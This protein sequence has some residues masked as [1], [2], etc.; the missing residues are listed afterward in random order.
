M[1][2]YLLDWVRYLFQLPDYYR[3]NSIVIVGSVRKENR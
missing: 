1:V 2:D 3:T